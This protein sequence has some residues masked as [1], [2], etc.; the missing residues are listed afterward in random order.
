MGPS[1]ETVWRV[2]DSQ[3]QCDALFNTYCFVVLFLPLVLLGYWA[4]PRR[5]WKLSYLTAMSFLFYALWDARFVPLLLASAVVDFLVAQR[6]EAARARQAGAG[7]TRAMSPKAWL[8]VSIAFN[9]GV[10]AF[11]KYAMF[12]ADNARSVF[13]LLGLPVTIPGFTIILPVGISFY[14][15]QTLSYT[16]DVYRGQVPATR[17]F[18]KYTCYVTMFPQLVAG[19]IVRY[20]KLDE[21]L[22]ALPARPHRG[23]LVTGASLFILGLAKKI[24][25]ADTVARIVEPLWAD[26]SG[27]TA[28]QAW[29]A[30]LGYTIQ[31]YFDF[32][33]Y[34]DMAIGLGAMMALRFPINFNAPYQAVNIS[35]FWRRWH[36]SLSTFLRDY[37]YIPLGGNRHGARRAQINMLIVMFLG[38]LWH[39]ANWTFVVWGVYHGLLL[40][41]YR[42]VQ[43]WW[44]RMHVA[45]QRAATLFLVVIGWV[46]FRA[47]NLGDAISVYRAMFF[48]P[49][50]GL[51]VLT[52]YAVLLLVVTY[53]FMALARPTA[54]LRMPAKPWHAAALSTLLLVTMVVM[55]SGQSP[56]LY[57]QF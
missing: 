47:N 21:Q 17:N 56:F 32:S 54:Q 27:L 36:I 10:L 2:V 51:A 5:A 7:G 45:A 43:P 20:A 38:G 13:D 9:L 55:G 50:L 8:I 6:I 26:P 34:S 15:F 30:A 3:F 52:P 12:F 1:I 18:L 53:A 31:L 49:E 46:V 28:V 48:G 11:F 40:A 37:L 22:D 24:L 39:G 44:D 29:Y 4:V 57:Y 23:L 42:Q 41:G 25:V 35:D 19:P 16:I 14:T 33:G